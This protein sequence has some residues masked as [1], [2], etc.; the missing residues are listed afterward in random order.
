MTTTP[1]QLAVAFFGNQAALAKAIDR[2]PTLV[3]YWVKGSRK[4]GARDAIAIERVTSGN[5]T[6][7]E[8]RPDIF[9]EAAE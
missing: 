9:G 6:R 1:I 4:V 8:L 5:P 7:H 2:T 3:S